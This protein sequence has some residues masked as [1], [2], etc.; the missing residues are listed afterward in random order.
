MGF[1][2]WNEQPVVVIESYATS[3]WPSAE[4]QE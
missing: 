1:D 4:V 3:A 2:F